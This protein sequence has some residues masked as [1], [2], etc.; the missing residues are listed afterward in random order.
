VIGEVKSFKCLGPFVQRDGGFGM[1][2]KRKIK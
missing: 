1:I 2:E